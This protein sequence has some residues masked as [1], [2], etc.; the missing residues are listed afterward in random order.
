MNPAA[1]ATQGRCARP[2]RDRPR[3]L[4]A[5]RSCIRLD[6]PASV[7]I[8]GARRPEQ[9]LV[10][11]LVPGARH[12]LPVRATG[13]DEHARPPLG[14]GSGEVFWPAGRLCRLGR[15]SRGGRTG[16][17]VLPQRPS[18]WRRIPGARPLGPSLGRTPPR[19]RSG[20]RA[21]VRQGPAPCWYVGSGENR[22]QSRGIWAECPYRQSLQNPAPW[23]R[24]CAGQGEWPRACGVRPSA[25][26]VEQAEVPAVPA[27]GDAPEQIRMRNVD[28]PHPAPGAAPCRSRTRA[29]ATGSTAHTS[30]WDRIQP[31]H[32]HTTG[33]PS[34][35]A[36]PSRPRLAPAPP[37][38]P[39]PR[40]L[41]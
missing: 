19:G 35:D 38:S 14:G 24:K 27:C 10:L 15:S 23:R 22:Q 17:P 32:S 39:H 6:N 40:P 34:D 37:C 9:H 28:T 13:A 26:G 36:H 8:R 1:S 30:P 16:Q 7:A 12:L 41:A 11:A 3:Q 4:L 33:A 20:D 29:A 25:P 21:G 2:S 5:G 31:G 18:T